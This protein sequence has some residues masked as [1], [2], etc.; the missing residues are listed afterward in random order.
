[1]RKIESSKERTRLTIFL[2]AIALLSYPILIHLSLAFDR[3]LVIAYTWLAIS[4]LG[5]AAA[6]RNANILSLLF[7]S[8]IVA[9]AI[10]LWIWGNEANLMYLPPVLV[11]AALLIVFAKTLLPGDIPL[12]SRVASAWR[13]TLDDAVA[14]YTRRVTCAWVV[15]FAIMML[16]SI[17][18]A[19]FAPVYIWSLFTNFLNYLMVLTFFVVEYQLRFVFLPNHEHLSFREFCRLLFSIDFRRLGR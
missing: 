17:A 7:F 10:G 13:G 11:N 2:I 3:P 6:I 5:M 16:E 15:F 12:V 8:L 14:H 9:V 18:L 4:V 19:L 1:M